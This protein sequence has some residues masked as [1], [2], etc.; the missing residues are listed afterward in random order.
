MRYFEK[1]KKI[2][3]LYNEQRGQKALHEPMYETKRLVGKCC[4]YVF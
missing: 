3:K 4:G 2:G 1:K